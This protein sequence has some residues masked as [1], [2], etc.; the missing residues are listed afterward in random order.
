M[1]DTL[2]SILFLAAL[3][4]FLVV[5]WLLGELDPFGEAE[6]QAILRERLH[7]QPCSLWASS[8]T[9]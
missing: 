1:K 7:Y 3:F 8:K 6:E 9:F 5:F 2:H 4:V